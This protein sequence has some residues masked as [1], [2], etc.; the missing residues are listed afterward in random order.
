MKYVPHKYQEAVLDEMMEK[1]KLA[2]LLDPGMGKTSICLEDFRRRRE[3]LIAE[4]ALVVAPLR[5]CHATWPNEVK[6]WTCFKKFNVHVAHGKGRDIH[7]INAADI[8]VINPEGLKWMLENDHALFDFDV[9]YADESTL[10]K[11]SNSGRSKLMYR[12]AKDIPFK[13]ILTG[14]PAPNGVEDLFGQFKV[15]GD[16]ILG[17]TL[18]GF[19]GDFHFRA[20]QLPFGLVWEPTKASVAAV[21][22]AIA[23]HSVRLD[24]L[25]HL[26]MPDKV[27]IERPI[28]LPQKV[29]KIYKGLSKDLMVE[30]QQGLVVAANAG[31][32]TSKC[33]QVANGAVYLSEDGMAA[34]E[35][36]RRIEWMHQEKAADLC[37]LY[38][39]LGGKPLLVA[40]E[41]KHD[42]SQIKMEVNERFGFTPRYI[43]ETTKAEDDA[44]L[45]EQWNA[46]DLPMLLINPMAASHGLNLQSG[47]HHVYWYSIIWNL[48]LYQQFNARLWRQG[49]TEGVFIHHAI[50]QGTIDERAFKA[51]NGKGF[52]QQSLLRALKN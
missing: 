7:R 10:F 8:V 36:G 34:S 32:A 46:G 50:T 12:A 41:F 4:R 28:T 49:Q 20:L 15:L 3:G 45:I 47:G 6:K 24:A 22:R 42:L 18:T 19:R 14:T 11:N 31:V 16:E 17:K 48:E 9:L 39:G 13:F 51:L 21:T 38:E 23:P 2:L 1:G 35:E 52:T 29:M 27:M 26:D 33:R 25:D 30:V 40:Y 37:D 43:G 44:N 5:V